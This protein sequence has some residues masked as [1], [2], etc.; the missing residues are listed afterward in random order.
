MSTQTA[1]QIKLE[2]RLRELWMAN[3]SLLLARLETLENDFSAWIESPGAADEPLSR[4]QMAAH[5]LAGV[6]GTFGLPQAGK[7]ASQLESMAIHA[8]TRDSAKIQS[9]LEELRRQVLSH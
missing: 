9:M 8:K 4:A 1:V 7:I 5:N 3:Q 6:L 2:A